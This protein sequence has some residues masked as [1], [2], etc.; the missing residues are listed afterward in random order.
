MESP[1]VHS[2]SP[3]P[4]HSSCVPAVG[5]GYSIQ[6]GESRSYNEVEECVTY[7]PTSPSTSNLPRDLK[8]TQSHEP[9]TSGPHGLPAAH[10]WRTG[11]TYREHT[12]LEG[13]PPSTLLTV[14]HP[15]EDLETPPVARD[16]TRRAP[17]DGHGLTAVVA[18]PSTG[19]L[20]PAEE[21][22]ISDRPT[23]GVVVCGAVPGSGR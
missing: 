8:I 7:T 19:R 10:G 15:G 14:S 9:A 22:S 13:Q 2:P 5:G 20:A 12:P 21:P 16:A 17:A 11:I 1:P 3:G 4:K 18:T 23:E 6:A